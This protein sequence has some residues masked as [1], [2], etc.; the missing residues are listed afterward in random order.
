MLAVANCTRGSRMGASLGTASN[1][2]SLL[3]ALR[4][5]AETAPRIPY[6][7]GAGLLPLPPKSWGCRHV[8]PCPAPYVTAPSSPGGTKEPSGLEAN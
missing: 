7:T 2:C 4:F 6:A 1:S 3:S 5:V 8:P